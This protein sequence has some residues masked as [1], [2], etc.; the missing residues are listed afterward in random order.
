MGSPEV[1][2]RSPS[3]K[4]L[5]SA[6]HAAVSAVYCSGVD[7]ARHCRIC[8][9]VASAGDGGPPLG[10]IVVWFIPGMTRNANGSLGW[11]TIRGSGLS[12]SV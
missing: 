6:S 1:F 9:K 11:S 5:V 2:L 4:A 10:M 8:A 12:G 3:K 7:T